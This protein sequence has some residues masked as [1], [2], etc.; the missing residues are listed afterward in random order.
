MTIKDILYLIDLKF[1]KK[2]NICD[3]GIYI[4]SHIDL[5]R[6]EYK[7]NEEIEEQ[8]LYK[9]IFKFKVQENE[10]YFYI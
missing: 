6:K 9:K 10:I 7:R 2:I 3:M 1:I 8:T 5:V 4:S